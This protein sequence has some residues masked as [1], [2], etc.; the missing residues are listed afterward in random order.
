MA[1]LRP[2]LTIAV[3]TF[4]RSHYL[5]DL[6]DSVAP[7]VAANADVELLVSDNASEDDTAAVIE[8]C[9]GRLGEQ[10]RVVRQPENIGSDAN[11]VFC[12]EQA[13]GRYV[14]ICGD[15]DVLAPEHNGVA[16]AVDRLLGHVRA[17]DFD[18]IY[19]TSF[20]FRDDWRTAAKTDPMGRRFHVIRSAAQFTRVV[21]IMFTFISGVVVNKDRY[22]ELRGMDASIEAPDAFVG[23]NLPQL[24]WTLPLLRAHRRSLVLWDR[25]VGGRRG[26]GHGYSLGTVFGRHLVATAARC[27]PDRPELARIL[28]NVTLRRWLPATIFALR[29]ALGPAAEMLAGSSA[30]RESYGS[31]VRF[32]LFTWPVLRLP[33]SLARVALRMGAAVSKVLYALEV[34]GFW[35]REMR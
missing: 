33:L 17:S 32:W 31:N 26:N 6:L 19:T 18:L 16:S 8:R 2:L 10:M 24:S 14:W 7:Q 5:R 3:P 27:L 34:R 13:R 23:T 4:N 20:A 30:L 35:R 1:E 22:I 15:D 28:L 29:T 9:R 25:P 21:N 11:F 12:F